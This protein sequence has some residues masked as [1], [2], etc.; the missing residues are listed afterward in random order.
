MVAT[1]FL[2]SSI[3]C[4]NLPLDAWVQS[5]TEELSFHTWVGWPKPC[6]AVGNDVDGDLILTDKDVAR[7][8]YDITIAIVLVAFTATSIEVLT[9]SMRLISGFGLVAVLTLVSSLAT[10]A[11]IQSRWPPWPAYYRLV[12]F[13]QEVAIFLVS[14]SIVVSWYAIFYQLTSAFGKQ[15]RNPNAKTCID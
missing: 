15:A 12:S 11:G 9:R 10:F 13:I 14:L 2:V 7:V 6:Y 3:A 1:G 5:K 4:L 8:V